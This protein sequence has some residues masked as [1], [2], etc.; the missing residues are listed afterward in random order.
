MFFHT[1][2]NF[3]YSG[4]IDAYTQPQDDFFFKKFFLWK[5]KDEILF[6]EIL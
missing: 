3:T 1:L 2:D 6:V 5:S 4:P